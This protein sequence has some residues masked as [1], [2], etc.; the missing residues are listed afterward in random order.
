MM[1]SRVRVSGLVFIHIPKTA[2]ATVRRVLEREYGSALSTCYEHRLRSWTKTMQMTGKK[3]VKVHA[4]GGHMPYG[5]HE[6]DPRFSTYMTMLRHPVDRLVSHYCYVRE[7]RESNLHNEVVTRGLTLEDYVTKVSTRHLIN[8]GQ[9]RL[10]GQ[11]HF[12]DRPS[13]ATPVTLHRALD[14]LERMVVGLVERFDESLLLMA[15]T[16]GW[17]TPYYTVANKTKERPE[18]TSLPEAAVTTICEANALDLVLYDRVRERFDQ[19]LRAQGS[20]FDRRVDAFREENS[21]RADPK[22]PVGSR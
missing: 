4:V 19:L 22:A 12:S 11:R 15:E 20:G 10:L 6:V 5:F 9:T 8:D 14:R 21:R 2:G 17:R 18:L 3:R 16:F 1:T 7:R 13:P